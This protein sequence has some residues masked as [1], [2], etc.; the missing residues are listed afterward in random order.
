MYRGGKWWHIL[1]PNCWIRPRQFGKTWLQ[2]EP[3]LVFLRGAPGEL[4]GPRL[5]FRGAQ[6][7]RRLLL[8]NHFSE[9]PAVSQTSFLHV[10][11]KLKRVQRKSH[12]RSGEAAPTFL[13]DCNSFFPFASQEDHHGRLIKPW[14]Q[15]KVATPNPPLHKNTCTGT[16]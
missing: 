2:R 3:W 1:K 11:A 16:A 6:G 10:A 12:S 7:K 4:L 13:F 5:A 8:H 15:S 9:L 14:C